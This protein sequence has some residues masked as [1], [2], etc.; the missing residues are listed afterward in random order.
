VMHVTA[1]LLFCYCKY[2]V[3]AL[4][5]FDSFKQ[6][7]FS[8]ECYHSDDYFSEQFK[9]FFP[10]VGCAVMTSISYFSLHHVEVWTGFVWLT[11]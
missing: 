3:M 9:F 2:C 1:V 5:Q 4:P 10:S 6:L 7:S 8:H 11:I